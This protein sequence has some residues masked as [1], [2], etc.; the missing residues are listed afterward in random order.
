MPGG[1]TLLSGSTDR[2]VKLWDL[3]SAGSGAAPAL[4][5]AA[6]PGGA[7][8]RIAVLPGARAAALACMPQG[9]APLAVLDFSDEA[10]PTAAP[11]ACAWPGGAPPTYHDVKWG[12]GGA[13]LFAAGRAGTV[14]KYI[15][16]VARLGARKRG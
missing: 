10:A 3:R 11:V 1:T 12:A 4:G 14:E 5:A 2:H 15:R 13:A 9:G 7:V 8:V 6:G 16:V